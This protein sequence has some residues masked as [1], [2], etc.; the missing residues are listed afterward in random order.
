MA[1]QL[2][3]LTDCHLFRDPSAE[4]Q[5]VCTRSAWL[6]ALQAIEPL[7]NEVDRLIVTGDFTHDDLPE[8]Y[9]PVRESLEAWWSK[10]RLTLGNHDVRAGLWQHAGDRLEQVEGRLVFRDSV[11]GWNLIGLDSHRPGEVVGEL[12]EPQRRWL[13]QELARA[14]AR[15]TAL[16]FHHP[17]VEFASPWMTAIALA[18]RAELGTL[19]DRHPQV[20][21]V[22]CGHVHHETSTLW[23]S[24]LVL[25]TPSTAVQFAPVSTT[26]VVDAVPPGYRVLELHD[27]GRVFTRVVRLLDSPAIRRNPG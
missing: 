8:T 21:L 27:D 9:Q 1:I 15:P 6:H 25:T 22:V 18:D 24:R 5:G 23:G 17:P 13:D 10:T 14:P 26:L 11:G 12:G 20:R 2:L 19:L 4:L 3:H 16:F 7:R